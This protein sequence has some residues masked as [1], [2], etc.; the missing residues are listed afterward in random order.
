MHAFPDTDL[1]GVAMEMLHCGDGLVQ[2]NSN[3]PPKALLISQSEV[4][5]LP[6]HSFSANHK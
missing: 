6:H 5:C 3:D 2:T 1:H 4:T